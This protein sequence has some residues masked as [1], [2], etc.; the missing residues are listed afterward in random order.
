MIP[1]L[2]LLQ[3]VSL[4]SDTQDFRNK[5]HFFFLNWCEDLM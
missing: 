5:K 4:V 2:Q 3:N 1:Q